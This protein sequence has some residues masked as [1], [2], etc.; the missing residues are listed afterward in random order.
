MKTQLVLK[1]ESYFGRPNYKTWQ[2]VCLA[3]KIS[4]ISM[5]AFSGL[6]MD[7]TPNEKMISFC[8]P[9]HLRGRP[10][11][12]L[13]NFNLEPSIVYRMADYLLVCRAQKNQQYQCWRCHW[14]WDGYGATWKDG[15]FWKLNIYLALHWARWWSSATWILDQAELHTSYCL[16]WYPFGGLGG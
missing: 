11:V 5:L 3:L 9:K 12:K 2:P 1:T 16:Y 6:E 14:F 8:K 7:V 10:T 4:I 15:L 13:C